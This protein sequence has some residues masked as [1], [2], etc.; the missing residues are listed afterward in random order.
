MSYIAGHA[1][2]LGTVF[3]LP[4]RTEPALSS[5]SQSVVYCDGS[6]LLI[7][8]NGGPYVPLL[9]ALSMSY[10]PFSAGVLSATTVQGAIDEIASMLPP[11]PADCSAFLDSI[12][13][14]DSTIA[15]AQG[16]AALYRNRQTEIA[17]IIA[18]GG[19]TQ[20]EIDVLNAESAALQV[21]IDAIAV[22][23]AGLEVDRATATQQYQTCSGEI[24]NTGTTAAR[25][26]NPPTGF[27][28]FDTDLGRPIWFKGSSSGW[29]DATGA[30]A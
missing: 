29:V 14:I 23:V 3:V 21:E 26:V 16:Q 4:G 30:P 22:Q 1:D 11:V 19:L 27:A 18:D 20:A 25:P 7:S 8:S 9:V 24:P 6:Q 13:V 5:P 17:T 15:A 12:T 2:G 28:Y 10:N